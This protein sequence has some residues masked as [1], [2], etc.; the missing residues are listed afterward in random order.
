MPRPPR[1]FE[2]GCIYHLT[3]HGVDDNPIFRT[4]DD[5]QDFVL[6]LGRVVRKYGWGLYAYCL[7]DTHIHLLV[8]AGRI[9]E[10]MRVLNGG[11]SR[12]FNERHGRRGA[13]FESRYRD[14]PMR[15]DEHLA[16]A[17]RYIED[18]RVAAGLEDDWVWRSGNGV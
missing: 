9:S 16:N 3:M 17:M 4:D 11:Y 8:E 18:N 14:T 13:L 10:G 7:M 2:L 1:N 12:A 6:R 5:R 15:D